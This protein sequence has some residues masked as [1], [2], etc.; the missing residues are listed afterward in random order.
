M[1]AQFKYLFICYRVSSGYGS[2]TAAA[3]GSTTGHPF[4][5]DSYSTGMGTAGSTASDVTGYYSAFTDTSTEQ[6]D[7]YG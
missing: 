3:G 2:D 1:E 4:S 5:S 6:G 7:A